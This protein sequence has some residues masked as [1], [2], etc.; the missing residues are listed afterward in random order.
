MSHQLLPSS[1]SEE[2]PRRYLPFECSSVGSEANLLFGRQGNAQFSRESFSAAT[3]PQLFCINS[4]GKESKA[5]LICLS[6]VHG[7]SYALI[8]AFAQLLR[9]VFIVFFPSLF[10]LF[11]PAA[12]T[13]DCRGR[14][15][16]GSEKHFCFVLLLYFLFLLH[17]ALELHT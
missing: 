2:F 13:P 5:F 6:S 10:L 15:G 1:A 3:F 14:R 8:C 9:F 7:I 12:L 4:D 16:W 17:P 11:P